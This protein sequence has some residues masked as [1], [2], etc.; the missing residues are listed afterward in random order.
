[1]CVLYNGGDVP[2]WVSYESEKSIKSFINV[3]QYH[4]TEQDPLARKL[5]LSSV[6]LC[7]LYHAVVLCSGGEGTPKSGNRNFPELGLL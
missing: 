6:S 7:S 1:M 4:N 3:E 5:E 2:V